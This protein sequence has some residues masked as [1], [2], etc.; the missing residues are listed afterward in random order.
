MP[1]LL[2]AVFVCAVLPA[3][4]FAWNVLLFREPPTV[5]ATS[6]GPLPRIA[7]LIP[8]RN[9]ERNIEWVV[10]SV[11]SSVRA[12]VE[13]IVYDDASTDGTAKIVEA[14]S[15]LPQLRLLRGK[16]LPSGWNGKQH[17]CWQLAQA[18]EAETLLF[19]DADVRLQPEC[20]ARMA[21]FQR[22][23]GAALVSGFPKLV[24]VTPLERLLLPKIHFVLLSYLPFARMRQSTSSAF[25][26]GCGQVLMVNRAAYMKAGGHAAIRTTMHDGLKL[27]ALMR[28]RGFRT[29]LADITKLAS[30]RMYR[31]GTEVWQGLGKNATEGM[32]APQRIVVFTALLLLGQVLPFVMLIGWLF[33]LVLAHTG[34]AMSGAPVWTRNEVDLSLFIVVVLLGAGI[35][36]FVIARRYK[37]S[38]ASAWF[39]PQAILLLVALQ[40][41]ALVRELSGKPVGWK[42]RQYPAKR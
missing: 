18:T 22:V 31:N 28:G 16:A 10:R 17:A 1:A 20:I 27:P 39:H 42:A 24:C 3:L 19:L 36:A 14:L 15:M 25:A 11:L 21:A 35:P 29:D 5:A 12:E 2:F 30:V 6:R 7:V 40:W 8:A 23:S 26:A 13:V 41:W 34:A 9:E 37:S 38:M 33:V 4:L 32:A